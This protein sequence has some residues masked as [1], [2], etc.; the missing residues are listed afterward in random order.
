MASIS[1]ING[2]PAGGGTGTFKIIAISPNAFMSLTEVDIE[3]GFLSDEEF[4]KPILYRYKNGVS[5][6][7]NS[8]IDEEFVLVNTDASIDVMSTNPFIVVQTSKFIY[9]PDQGDTLV[10]EGKNYKVLRHEPDGTGISM[11]YYHYLK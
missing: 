5:Q 8:I 6:T 11:I 9:E 2:I 3:E 10:I 1:I 4:A 7:I